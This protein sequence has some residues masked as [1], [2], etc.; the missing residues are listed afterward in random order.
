MWTQADLDQVQQALANGQK[1]VTFADGRKLEYQTTADLMK[2]R[3][4]MKADIAASDP[5]KPTR[6]ATV[7]RMG[8]R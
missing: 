8:R 1:S 2:L 3:N 7:A 5:V 4:Q 6:R